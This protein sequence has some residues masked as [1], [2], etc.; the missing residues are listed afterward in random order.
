MCGLLR[1][2]KA[3]PPRSTCGS[4][5]STSILNTAAPV[6]SGN[7]ASSVDSGITEPP[8]KFDDS[9]SEEGSCDSPVSMGT[10]ISPGWSARPRRCGMA[11]LLSE[12]STTFFTSST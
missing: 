1:A 6:K 3:R 12:F 7:S 4:K 2:R 5:P 9:D 8:S 10:R 11:L